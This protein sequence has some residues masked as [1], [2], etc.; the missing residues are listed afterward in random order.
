MNAGQTADSLNIGFE[1]DHV[2][3]AWKPHGLLTSGN[4][5]RTLLRRVRSHVGGAQSKSA[6][7]CHRLDFPTSGWVVFGKHHEAIRLLGEAFAARRVH[8][9]YVALVHG[10]TPSAF[11]THWD[12]DTKSAQT[13]FRTVA[14]GSLAGAG[15]V[16][17]VE[18][19]PITGRTH[20]IRRHLWGCGHGIVGDDTYL[21]EGNH[22]RGKGLFL[23]AYNLSF[24]H[25]I[26]PET[27]VAVSALP[28]KKFTKIPFVFQSEFIRTLRLSSHA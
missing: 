8:K 14:Q 1:D 12:V 7:A 24:E 3:V 2:L 5:G 9:R 23:C 26:Q 13:H 20:Q 6:A 19:R 11:G 25:P 21:Y 4:D 16:S 18:A 10:Q 27:N 17:L 15:N 28:S 22:Y